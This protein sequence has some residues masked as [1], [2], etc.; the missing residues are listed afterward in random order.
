MLQQEQA[1]DF[2]VATGHT[3]TLEEFVASA[4]L[5]VSLDWRQH[6]IQ[7]EKLFRPTDIEISR[8]NPAKARAKLGWSATVSGAGVVQGML[9]NRVA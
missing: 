1:E 2:V 7:D 9:D 6:V 5:S 4:F 3:F 8:A